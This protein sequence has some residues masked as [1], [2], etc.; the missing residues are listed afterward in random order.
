MNPSIH[1]CK[2]CG[3]TLFDVEVKELTDPQ[4][5]VITFAGGFC[6][7]C[8]VSTFQCSGCMSRIVV[9]GNRNSL[10]FHLWNTRTHNLAL[11]AAPNIQLPVG[12]DA[13]A[14]YFWALPLPP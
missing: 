4:N 6:P 7:G 1:A 3:W 12:P 14:E 8:E 13:G 9:R 2:K 11:Q 5:D 10:H